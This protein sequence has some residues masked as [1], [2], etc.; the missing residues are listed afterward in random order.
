MGDKDKDKD[1]NNE[2]NKDK[3]KIQ[4]KSK[5]RVKGKDKVKPLCKKC[6]RENAVKLLQCDGCKQ[7]FHISC[8]KFHLTHN[9]TV[10][11]RMCSLCLF[12]MNSS[13]IARRTRFGSTCSAPS[14]RPS[15]PLVE[16]SDFVFQSQAHSP[17]STP[18]VSGSGLQRAVAMTTDA[19]APS[20]KMLS[21]ILDKLNSMDARLRAYE[22]DMETRMVNF[23]N[24]VSSKLAVLDKLPSLI[25]KVDTV[26]ADVVTLGDR[27]SNMEVEQ[28]KLRA[29]VEHLKSSGATG[30]SDEVTARIEKAEESMKEVAGAVALINAERVKA[31][32]DIIVSGLHVPEKADLKLLVLAVLHSLNQSFELSNIVS[33]IFLKSKLVG[34]AAAV[35]GASLHP[36][37]VEVLNRPASLLVRVSS[38]EL[39]RNLVIAKIRHGKLHTASLNADLVVASG[40]TLPLRESLIN[41]NEF[42]PQD[43][44]NL[45]L[46]V[47]E[48]ARG[49]GYST[50]VHD[51]SVF[52]KKKKADIPTRI[53]SM[54]DLKNFLLGS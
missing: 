45:R 35:E 44:Y 4:D 21:E 15:S 47:K 12:E 9:G 32:P 3:D 36:G 42:L 26:V 23:Q 19:V 48:A 41:V 17:S 31:S 2:K 33:V 39:A 5:D 37:G 11:E 50:F 52:I 8:T 53:T 51:G 29:T 24:D 54:A 34:A 30:I 40:V 13:P 46:A 49:K 6:Q 28:R 10:S 25:E 38:N 7:F 22:R 16:L 18:G 27:V 20:D 14:S 43:Q 1:K